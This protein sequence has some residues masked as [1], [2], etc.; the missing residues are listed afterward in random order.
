MNHHRFATLPPWVWM[1]ENELG[2]MTDGEVIVTEVENQGIVTALH[3]KAFVPIEW[4][5]VQ[6]VLMEAFYV[7][8]DDFDVVSPS[9]AIFYIREEY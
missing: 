3:L 8:V 5:E 2:K 9:E 7:I 1:I 4:Y 6:D